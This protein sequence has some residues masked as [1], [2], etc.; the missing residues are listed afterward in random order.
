MRCDVACLPAPRSAS[1]RTGTSLCA[2]SRIT[3]STGRM[4]ALTPST[5]ASPAGSAGAPSPPPFALLGNKFPIFTFSGWRLRLPERVRIPTALRAR[6]L[7]LSYSGLTKTGIRSRSM[8]SIAYT[9]S[10]LNQR[11]I[12]RAWSLSRSNSTRDL[13]ENFFSLVR[14]FHLPGLVEIWSNSPCPR[15]IVSEEVPSSKDICPN[16]EAEGSAVS[17]PGN[18]ICVRSAAVP[19]VFSVTDP[20]TLSYL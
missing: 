16:H 11:G 6:G 2:S 7:P 19:K 8:F 12:N 18:R 14:A 4:L 3:A 17:N 20:T 9:I 1:T 15:F 10:V 13:W 5:N